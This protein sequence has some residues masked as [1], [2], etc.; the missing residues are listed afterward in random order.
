MKPLVI[1]PC[2]VKQVGIHPF[3]C[4]GE[5]YINAV[6]HG[7]DSWPLLLPAFGGGAD[8]EP[9]TG[10]VDIDGLLA[11][12]D[13]VFLPGS[14]SNVAPAEYGAPDD[15]DMALDLQRDAG[16]LVLIRRTIALGVPLFA[17]CRGIQELNVALGGTLEPA[18]HEQP[19]MM[20]HREETSQPRHVQYAPR[21]PVDLAEGGML[22]RLLGARQIGVNSLHGQGLRDLA[23]GLT[24]EGRAPDG[25]VEA[26]SMPGAPGFVLGVQWHP[27]W[28]WRNDP[29][30][31]AL[32]G[33]FGEA[34]RARSAGRLGRA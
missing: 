7:A 2:D 33:A 34:V 13:G 26:V 31:V 6:A 10:H 23:P 19:G 16:T 21:H 20:D 25:L 12:V 17:V 15:P 9:L 27:E 28:G 11:T 22:Q 5:K 3:H 1:L 32:F 18:V 29:A 8:L 30:S 24:V 14:H 4:V